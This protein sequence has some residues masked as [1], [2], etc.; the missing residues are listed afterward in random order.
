MK[1]TH[2]LRSLSK[3]LRSQQ[4]DAEARLWY[5]LCNRQIENTKFRRQQ[6]IDKY[7]VDF[8]SFD[9]KIVIEVDG[10]QHNET[11][12]QAQDI[13]RT[14]ILE[15]KGYTVLRYWDNEVLQ[16]TES[17][18]EDIRQKISQLNHP[19]LTSPVKGEE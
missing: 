12:Y 7:I 5:Y 2:N 6:Q 4:T 10:G 19:H 9:N 16:D 1:N 13:Q 18:V 14:K 3:K 8:V 17:V 11:F 15:Q